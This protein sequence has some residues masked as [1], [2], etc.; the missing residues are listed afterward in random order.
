MLPILLKIC[1][2]RTKILGKV[3]RLD[4][5]CPAQSSWAVKHRPLFALGCYESS[6]VWCI[7]KRRQDQTFMQLSCLIF[8]WL[9]QLI[10]MY[11]L[12]VWMSQD[13]HPRR[14]SQSPPSETSS[15]ISNNRYEVIHALSAH[16]RRA[17]ALRA[18]GLLLADGAP[19]VG[20]RIVDCP[21]QLICTWIFIC[22]P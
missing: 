3:C 20:R 1:S 9:Y 18:L 5:F 22:V 15:N 4:I 6:H 17:C 11:P 21:T 13:P 2:S 19:T 7:N 16:A 12:Q 14:R 8:T 10:L